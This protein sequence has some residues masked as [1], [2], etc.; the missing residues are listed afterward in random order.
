M[1]TSDNNVEFNFIADG[2]SYNLK[3]APDKCLS[4]LK[5]AALENLCVINGWDNK[6][7]KIEKISKTL[8]FVGAG[9]L[10]IASNVT[11][12]GFIVSSIVAALCI[13]LSFAGKFFSN[14][15]NKKIKPQKI[16]FNRIHSTLSRELQERTE[17]RKIFPDCY[18]EKLLK[19]VDLCI[20]DT[21]FEV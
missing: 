7:K 6:N 9:A 19:H 3:T 17:F 15:N 11:G 4:I 21:E 1:Q 16:V 20:L 5:K 10:G 8:M 2:I 12:T 14:K 18:N 13:P